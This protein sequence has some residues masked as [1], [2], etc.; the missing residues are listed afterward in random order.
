M[1]SINLSDKD[2]ANILLGQH[3]QEAASL[4]N[5]IL[6]ST[7]NT[8]RQAATTMLQ[9]TFSHQKKIFDLMNSKGWYQVQQASPQEISSIAQSVSSMQ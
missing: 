8:V 6:E 7:N 9:E 2:M 1:P 5:L 3:K 4:T